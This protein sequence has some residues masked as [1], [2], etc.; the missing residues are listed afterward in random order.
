[1]PSGEAACLPRAISPSGRASLHILA[2]SHVE[3]HLA[4]INCPET[5]TFAQVGFVST[6]R[7]RCEIHDCRSV[8]RQKEPFL[9]VLILFFLRPRPQLS[10]GTLLPGQT[11][12]HAIALET[13]MSK[14]EWDWISAPLCVYT[15]TSSR[16]LHLGTFISQRANLSFSPQLVWLRNPQD[17]QGA[18]SVLRGLM[19][20]YASEHRGW[21]TFLKMYL[22]QPKRRFQSASHCFL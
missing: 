9:P 20:D 11:D 12:H 5:D 13:S 4:A 14:Q 19:M 18:S 22:F 6:S 1:M 16:L 21:K 17:L 15:V 10:M 7:L 2:S 8:M 3:N